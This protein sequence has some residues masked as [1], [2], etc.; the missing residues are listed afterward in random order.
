MTP[1][2]GHAEIQE[3]LEI[4]PQRSTHARCFVRGCDQW[5]R[6]ATRQQHG[7][8]CPVHGI[9]LHKSK[10]YSY[11]RAEQNMIAGRDL[12]RQR[13]DNHPFKVD[14]L[15]LGNENSEDALSWNVFRTLHEARKLGQLVQLLVGEE[16]PI[17]PQLY[18][19]GLQ[20]CDD[21]GEPWSLLIK[22]RERFEQ[23]LPVDRPKTEPD[24]AIHLPGRY[25]IL[26]EAKFTSPNTFY[27]HGP[28][29]DSKSLTLQ[30]LRTIYQDPDNQILDYGLAA[31]QSRIFYQLWRNMTFAEWM[32]RHDHPHTRAYHLN[33]VRQGYEAESAT[34]F[35]TLVR[36]EFQNRFQQWT[37]EHL[38]HWM[39]E[40]CSEHPQIQTC[41]NY[42]QNKTANLKPAFQ[43]PR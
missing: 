19:W 2:L 34:E 26:I 39:V 43:L 24:I 40:S 16:S 41:A 38:Y 11:A 18:L 3:R 29:K 10:T 31:Q 12:Y 4:H 14:T 20:I 35:A 36:P 13:I 9:R 27:E 37:W 28:R 25:L 7:E 33:L 5:L 30:E 42:L 17:E 6:L 22:A 21:S 15:K 23:R 1:P 8:P 32:A